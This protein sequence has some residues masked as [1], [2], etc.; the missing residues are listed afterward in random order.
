MKSKINSIHEGDKLMNQLMRNKILLILLISMVA[1]V[2]VSIAQEYQ[3]HKRGMLHETVFN[4]GDIGRPWTNNNSGSGDNTNVPLM[5]W[6]SN[7]RT[8]VNG[9]TYDGQHNILGGGLYLGANLDGQSG[10]DKRIYS[11]CGAVGSSLPEVVVNKWVFP[12]SITR[13]ENYPILADGSLNSSYNPD[14]AEE[15]IVAKWGTTLGI[16]VTR[17]SRSWSYPDYDDLIIYEYELE[18]TGD[19]NGDGVQEQTTTLKDFMAAF[20]YG[21]APSMYGYQRY[22]QTWKYNGGLYQADNFNIWDSD[23]WLSYNMDSKTSTDPNLPGGKPEPDPVLFKRFSE[24][25]ENGGGFASPQCPGY[26]MLYYPLDNLAILD[27]VDL[28]RNES[29]FVKLLKTS[30]TAGYYELDPL[31]RVKQP[32]NNKITTG[33][34]SSSKLITSWLSPYYGR[35]ASAWGA[36]TTEKIPPTLYGGDGA[37]WAAKWT[38]RSKYNKNQSAQACSKL[39]TFGPYT[40]KIGAKLK[41]ALAE[42]V[43]YGQDDMKYVEGGN[44]IYHWSSNTQFSQIPGMDRKVVLNG[45]V[46]TEHYLTDYGYPDYVNSNVRTVQDVAKKA[47][48]A[49]LGQEPTVPVWPEDNPASGSYKIP[50]PCP[51]PAIEV[52]NTASADIKLEWKR[53]AENFTHP[54]LMGT[55]TKY[56]IYKSLSGMGPWKLVTTVNVG[57]VN[58]ENIYEYLDVDPDFKIGESRYYSVTSVDDKGNESGKTNLIQFSKKVGAVEKMGKVYVVP[59]P[60]ISKSGFAGDDGKIGFYGLPA[61]CTIRIFTYAGQLVETIEHDAAD[62]YSTEWF[63][64]SRNG[65]EIASGVYLYIVTASNGDLAKGKFVVIK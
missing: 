16:N 58:S 53:S 28:T 46:M 20:N 30:T 23:Y 39:N 5:E 19:T 17:T 29:D 8:I 61:K 32:F 2:K 47:F 56:N 4:T 52:T 27:P 31:G 49:Y 1:L 40:L 35:W 14:E 60:F 55:L 18:Y 50:V 25:G 51:A 33:I 12:L 13:T 57:N 41:F 6:P 59:N 26:A 15:I 43:G 21:F 37:L 34:T 63:Q 10:D 36:S 7:S 65:Q 11:F 44:A 64:T 24:T 42:V 62:S 9:I 38:G 3:I 54:R 22:Y 48:Q 45:Q